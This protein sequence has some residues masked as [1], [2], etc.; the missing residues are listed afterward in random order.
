MLSGNF[1]WWSVDRGHLVQLGHGR[2]Y[3]LRTSQEPSSQLPPCVLVPAGLWCTVSFGGPYAVS[4]AAASRAPMSPFSAP[5]RVTELSN[6]N[7]CKSSW[8]EKPGW[9]M[10][11]FAQF[12]NII[13]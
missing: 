12:G 1:P 9:G 5:S 3:L 10:R 6:Q 2:K 8:T 13:P 4:Q 11:G 7:G